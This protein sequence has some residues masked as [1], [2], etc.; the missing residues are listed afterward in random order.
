[1]KGSDEPH[2]EIQPDHKKAPGQSQPRL[3]TKQAVSQTKHAL[4]DIT[5]H[6]KQDKEKLEGPH[7]LHSMKYGSEDLLGMKTKVS[8]VKGT[9]TGRVQT[10]EALAD[11]GGESY[12]FQSI[13][14]LGRC[15]L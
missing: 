7:M 13:G 5:G 8:S 12:C 6:P 9:K 1:M 10:V 14:P 2:S 4:R 15:F 3:K 11:S